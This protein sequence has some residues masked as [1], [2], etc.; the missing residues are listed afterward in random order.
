MRRRLPGLLLA[1]ALGIAAGGRAVAAPLD[2]VAEIPVGAEPLGIALAP[3]GAA[4][5]V[6]AGEK[7]LYRLATPAEGEPPAIA[8]RLDLAAEGRLNRVVVAPEDGTI[9]VTASVAGQVL[10]IR[11]DL[12]AVAA[13]IAVGAFPQGMALSPGKLWVADSGDGTVAMVDRAQGTV[14]QHLDGGDRPQS[15]A[16]DLAAGRLI[17]VKSTTRALWLFSLADGSAA[18]RWEQGAFVRPMDLAVLP[19]GG[20]LL[21]DAGADRLLHLGPDGAVLASIALAD[22][23]CEDCGEEFTPMAV[24][25]SPDGHVAAVASRNGALSLIDVGTDR[26]LL[27]RRVGKDLRGVVFDRTGRRLLATSFAEGK[28]LVVQGP[29]QALGP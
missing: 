13:R 14:L 22:P 18:G 5:V 8:G 2:L 4:L 24:A 15:V 21:A 28:V 10:A 9:Y 27:S 16:A 12:S 6:A 20:A 11:P 29:G 19:E 1:L 25:L 23:G 26:L 17:L 3:D 7:A